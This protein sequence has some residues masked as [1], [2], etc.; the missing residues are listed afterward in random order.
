M[1]Y[2]N[3]LPRFLKY[4]KVNVSYDKILNL[5]IISRNLTSY[6]I[7]QFEFPVEKFREDGTLEKTSQYIIK[8][9]EK[10]NI[11]LFTKAYDIYDKN[12]KNWFCFFIYH[13]L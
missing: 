1:E 6:K 3:L 5:A 10:E 8:W 9:N 13:I 2:P 7:K 4:V 12:R 11:K